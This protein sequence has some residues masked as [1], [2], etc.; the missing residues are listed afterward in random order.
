M[1]EIQ[2]IL[3]VQQPEVLEKQRATVERIILQ[4]LGMPVSFASSP[5]EVDEGA[6]FDV[7]IAPTAPWLPDVLHK[8]PALR[9]VHFLSAGVEKIWMMDFDWSELML[10]KSSGVHA[11]PMSEYA[12]GAMLYFAK[13]FDRFTDQSQNKIWQRE[14]LSELTDCQLVVVGMGSVGTAV[15][16]RSRAFGM[17][18]RGVARTPRTEGTNVI[19]G[20]DALP[21]L[22]ED[23]DYV[24]LTVPLTPSTTGLV[25]EEFFKNLKRGAVLVDMSRGGIVAADAVVNALDCGTL[26]GAALDVFEEEPLPQESPLWNRSNVLITPHVAG[27]TPLYVE[28]ALGIFADNARSYQRSLGLETIINQAELY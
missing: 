21:D 5:D 12:L 20:L 2:R 28:R 11:A 25:G 23:A 6:T 13:Q 24:V 8:L 19:D 17:N 18:V 9:W 7:V 22:V 26:R 1:P 15:A 16:E 4:E 3:F 27:T 10:T 14:W